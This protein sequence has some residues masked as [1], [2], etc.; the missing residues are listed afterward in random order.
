M[1]GYYAQKNYPAFCSPS[2]FCSWFVGHLSGTLILGGIIIIVV[3]SE[4]QHVGYG[5]CAR[6]TNWNA[7]VK[8]CTLTTSTRLIQIV[9]LDKENDIKNHTYTHNIIMLTIQKMNEYEYVGN[10][11]LGD[12]SGDI[13]IGVIGSFPYMA[14]ITTRCV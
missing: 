6:G 3:G 12:C 8:N 5:R 7:G 1:L 10:W 13:G 11:L 9:Q 4:I 14:A 2:H